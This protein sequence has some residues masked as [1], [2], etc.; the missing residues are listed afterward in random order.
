MAMYPKPSSSKKSPSASRQTGGKAKEGMPKAKAKTP[1]YKVGGSY[2][3]GRTIQGATIMKPR[4]DRG[5]AAREGGAVANS[6]DYPSKQAYSKMKTDAARR[7][8]IT[9][10]T[11]TPFQKATQVVTRGSF[12]GKATLPYKEGQTVST[13]KRKP[14]GILGMGSTASEKKGKTMTTVKMKKK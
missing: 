7:K 6:K 9:Q 5:G 11:R 13:A 2:R 4:S 14:K 1:D 10:D 8:P 3:S 12:M